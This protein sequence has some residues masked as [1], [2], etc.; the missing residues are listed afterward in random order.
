LISLR[1]YGRT[2]NLVAMSC[3]LGVG[4]SVFA[5]TPTSGSDSSAITRLMVGLSDHSI[6]PADVLDPSLSPSDRSKNLSR[7]RDP[8]YELSLVPTEGVP[9]ITGDSASVPVRVHFRTETGQVETNAT[10]RFVRRNNSWYFSSFD[11]L[12]WPALLIG[13]LAVCVIAGVGYAT[14]VLVLRTRLLRRGQLRGV[15]GIKIFIPVFWPTLFR[16]AR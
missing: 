12:S 7:F 1:Q 15:N 8:H 6:A 10:V 5:Q 2:V 9:V 13:V 3:L 4:I 16:Q 11:F 14:G